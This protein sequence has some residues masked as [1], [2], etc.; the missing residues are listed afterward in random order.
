MWTLDMKITKKKKKIPYEMNSLSNLYIHIYKYIYIYI[1]RQKWQLIKV[2]RCN[3]YICQM[4][5]VLDDRD[6]PSINFPD[7]K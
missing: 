3:L 2:K 6:K 7:N 5:I 4:F 1:K